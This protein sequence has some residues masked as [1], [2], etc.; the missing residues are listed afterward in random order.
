MHDYL[1]A[2]I[3]GALIG[4]AAVTIMATHGKIMGVSGIV[5]RLLPPAASDWPWRLVFIAGMLM[6]PLLASVF[7]AEPLNIVVSNNIALLI[8]DS[9]GN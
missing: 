8:I 1:L 9:I 4:L 3:G 5:S 2:L 6:T 7:A